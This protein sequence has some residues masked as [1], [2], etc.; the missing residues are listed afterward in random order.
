MT[1]AAAR[2]PHPPERSFLLWGIKP[3]FLRYLEHAAPRRISGPWM[4]ELSAFAFEQT[5]LDSRRRDF[6]GRVDVDAH[7][8]LLRIS[9]RDPSMHLDASGAGTVFFFINEG[10]ERT[11]MLH[12]TPSSPASWRS[13]LTESGARVFDDVYPPGTA[14]ADLVV[15]PLPRT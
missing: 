6:A 1:A 9:L 4:P 2:P 10:N 12:V 5:F 14:M 11:D 13:S 7:G 3:S 8:G 15:A